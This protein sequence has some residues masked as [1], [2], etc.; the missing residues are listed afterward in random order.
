VGGY[1][2]DV[3]DWYDDYGEDYADEEFSDVPFRDPGGRSALRAATRGNPRDRPCPTCGRKD[4][5][6]RV[7]EARGYQCDRCADAD[8]GGW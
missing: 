3:E 5:L 1:R 8:E 4:V 2:H 7:D 6:T